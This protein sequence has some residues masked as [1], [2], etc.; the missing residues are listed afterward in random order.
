MTRNHN[1]RRSPRAIAASTAWDASRR[2]ERIAV[3]I[4][5]AVLLALLGIVAVPK[6]V[7]SQS[8]ALVKLDMAVIAKG[9]RAS[10]LT[11]STVVNDK[12]EKIGTIDDLVVDRSKV[13]AAVLQVGGFLGV[14]AR[15]VAVPYETL[16]IDDSGRRIELPGATKEELQKLAE[17]KYTS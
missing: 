15:L 11:G 10:K 5:G 4:A 16:K 14:G 12:N 7:L 8:V 6:P 17:F 1:S 3:A 2:N 13:L 9:F